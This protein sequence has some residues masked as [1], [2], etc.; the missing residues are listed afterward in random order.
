[1][2]GACRR[3]TNTCRLTHRNLNYL[4]TP[5]VNP[6]P[7][8]A[9][10]SPA[11][12]IIAQLAARGLRP[13]LPPR[14]RAPCGRACPNLRALSPRART[15]HTNP[16]KH[17]PNGK[18]KDTTP[19]VRLFNILCFCLGCFIVLFAVVVFRGRV[20]DGQ[21]VSLARAVRAARE[22]CRQSPRN[23]PNFRP[24]LPARPA[25]HASPA[26]NPCAPSL[27]LHARI[28]SW[29]SLRSGVSPRPLRTLSPAHH[30]SPARNPC[31]SSLLR[32]AACAPPRT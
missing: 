23:R 31:A 21:V 28:T 13:R 16:P 10:A 25:F 29:G 17:R 26:H 6:P 8:C 24:P 9:R 7:S 2:G 15:G 19:Q 4:L 12:A 14:L 30:A 11:L 27:L 1:M 20:L 18:D 22:G 32:P 3:R 5:A